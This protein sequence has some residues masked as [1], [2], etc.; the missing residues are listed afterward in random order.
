MMLIVKQVYFLT[1]SVGL[2]VAAVLAG[3]IG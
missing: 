2:G 3:R 1:M